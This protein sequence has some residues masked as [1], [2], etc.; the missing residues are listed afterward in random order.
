MRGEH[1]ELSY[2]FCDKGKIQ[3]WYIPGTTTIKKIVTATLGSRI[4]K[5]KTNYIWII[6]SGCNVCEKSQEQVEKEFK[7]Q[8]II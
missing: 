8:N 1:T 5:R 6:K 2:P 4:Q 3:A 7:K